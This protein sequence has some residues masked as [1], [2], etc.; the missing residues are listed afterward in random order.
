MLSL[1]F[2]F[3]FSI[4]AAATVDR[5]ARLSF[6]HFLQRPM[7]AQAAVGFFFLLP[8]E[9]RR[10]DSGYRRVK[11][12]QTF[13][14]CSRVSASQSGSYSRTFFKKKLFFFSLSDGYGCRSHFLSTP[15]R[16]T[17][18]Q[19]RLMNAPGC[20]A[21]THTHTR[22]HAETLSS[23]HTPPFSFDSST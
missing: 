9:H 7:E 16:L 1:I 11:M 2:H 3:L 21:M 4:T 20:P 14:P 18:N 8:A 17:R 10:L 12:Q 22:A 5:L 13:P 6:L 15:A 23:L 19:L